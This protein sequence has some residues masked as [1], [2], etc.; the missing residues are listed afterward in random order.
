MEYEKELSELIGL[1]NRAQ[2]AHWES[3]FREVFSK[4]KQGKARQSYKYVLGADGGM[5][6]FSDAPLSLITIEEMERV[7]SKK[8]RCIHSAKQIWVYYELA[9]S[10]TQMAHGVGCRYERPIVWLYA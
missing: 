5:G 2:E 7:E 6:S 4:Y 3:Y 10:K 9:A 8:I 1:L